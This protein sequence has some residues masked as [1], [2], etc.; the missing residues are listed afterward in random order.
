MKQNNTKSV[1]RHTLNV[2]CR[3]HFTLIELLVVIAIIAILAGMLLPA[4]NK[5]RAAARSAA[6]VSNLKQIALYAQLYGEDY[7]DYMPVAAS[8]WGFRPYHT[9]G[10][11]LV[12]CGYISGNYEEFEYW[13]TNQKFTAK[14]LV[15]QEGMGSD[16]QGAAGNNKAG[17]FR[18]CGSHYGQTMAVANAHPDGWAEYKRW[19]RFRLVVSPTNLYMYGDTTANNFMQFYHYSGSKPNIRHNGWAN[20]AFFD[21]H[22]DKDNHREGR[23]EEKYKMNGPWY[24]NGK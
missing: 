15:C 14:V 23:T 12:F 17:T 2:F 19:L 7:D 4:L 18:W 3:N 11:L 20:I 9:F 8:S 24:N 21:G 16:T 22:V 6:C 1:S 10:Q 13:N 5:A